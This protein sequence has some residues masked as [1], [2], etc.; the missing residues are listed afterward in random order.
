VLTAASLDQ[1]SVA[2]CCN[3]ILRVGNH[4]TRRHDSNCSS[5]RTHAS[6]WLAVRVHVYCPHSERG[7][8]ECIDFYSATAVHKDNTSIL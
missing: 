1:C 6:K 8:L 4:G 5:E 7:Q 3:E 2:R